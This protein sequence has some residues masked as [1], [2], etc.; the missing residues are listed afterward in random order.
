MHCTLVLLQMELSAGGCRENSRWG[1]CMAVCAQNVVAIYE[2]TLPV[3]SVSCMCLGVRVV[4]VMMRWKLTKRVGTMVLVV[5]VWSWA[6]GGNMDLDELSTVPHAMFHNPTPRILDGF[7]MAAVQHDGDVLIGSP[8]ALHAG[9]DTGLAYLF[10]QQGRVLHTFE[11]PFVTP[12]ALFGQAVAL[13]KQH[14]IIGAPHARDTVGTQTGAAYIFDR[15]TA[16]LRFTVDNPQPTSGVFGHAV[17]AEKNRIVIGDPQASTSSSFHTGAAY[18]FDETTSVLQQT[19]RPVADEVTHATQFGYAVAVIGEY[20]FVGAPFG[21]AVN[22]DAGIVYLYHA[23]TGNLVRTFEPPNPSQVSM[24]GWALAANSRVL[25]IGALG[26]HDRYREEGIAY[27]F[28]VQSGKL[29]HRLHNPSPTERAHFGKSVAIL[30]DRVAVAAPGDRIQQS[31]KVAGG[32][33][34]IFDLTT[35]VLLQTLCDPLPATGA[36][37]LFGETLFAHGNRLVVGAPFG[38]TNLELDAGILYQFDMHSSP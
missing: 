25:L 16:T 17:V 24:F 6:Y 35:G 8:Y 27:L 34:S 12:G 33:V 31:G 18:L 20:I 2:W 10:D 29:L 11:N 4:I 5:G 22:H 7:G 13:T 36:S 37:D 9:R 14:V 15:K 30:N 26:F 23:K 3:F 32:C 21:P 1:P 38:G 19:F 28:D